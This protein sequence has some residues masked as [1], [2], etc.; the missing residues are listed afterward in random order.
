MLLNESK[1]FLKEYKDKLQEY[2]LRER[3][4]KRIIYVLLII[5]VVSVGMNIVIGSRSE[6][7]RRSYVSRIQG[8]LR[9]LEVVLMN[10]HN[11]I[12]NE[13]DSRIVRELDSLYSVTFTL[14]S[15]IGRLASH[16]NF[17]GPIPNTHALY[18]NVSHLGYQSTETWYWRVGSQATPEDIE[19]FLNLLNSWAEELRE[20]RVDLGVEWEEIRQEGTI[21]VNRPNFRM[22]T[23][24]LLTRTDT[25]ISS[26]RNEAWAQRMRTN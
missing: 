22:S 10:L 21:I 18:W 1:E 23:R 5:C 2:K 24:Q 15:D 3:K 8:G 9:N 19:A 4:L 11:A 20:L 6:N 17:N 14:G 25:V 13:D 12:E 16:Q 26:I 7:T